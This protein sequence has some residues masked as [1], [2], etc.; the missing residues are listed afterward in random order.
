MGFIGMQ[1]ESLLMLTPKFLAC[2]VSYGR[3]PTRSATAFVRSLI[4]GETRA[5]KNSVQA[6]GHNVAQK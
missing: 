6:M 5:F 4:S 1:N 2:E 3:L